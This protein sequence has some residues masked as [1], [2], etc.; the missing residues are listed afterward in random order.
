MTFGAH[1]PGGICLEHGPFD[2]VTCLDCPDP[3]DVAQP[4][5][6]FPAQPYCECG[7]CHL[8]PLP[9]EA[10][11]VAGDGDLARLAVLPGH[12]KPY[13]ATGGFAIE[14]FDGWLAVSNP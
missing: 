11:A 12:E 1:G 9:A 13:R 6:T 5:D 10:W 2:G 14:E 7:H 8:Q 4:S 3:R